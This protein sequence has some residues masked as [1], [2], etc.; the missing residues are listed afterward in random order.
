MDKI[1]SIKPLFVNLI[2]GICDFRQQ[3]LTTSYFSINYH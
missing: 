3:L 1:L 2:D